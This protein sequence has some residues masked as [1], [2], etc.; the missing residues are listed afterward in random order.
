MTR[1]QVCSKLEDDLAA[2]LD[3]SDGAVKATMEEMVRDSVTLGE[4]Q[5]EKARLELLLKEVGAV[6]FSTLAPTR[7]AFFSK[8]LDQRKAA[9]HTL[10]G[11]ATVKLNSLGAAAPASS[12]VP[13]T[14]TSGTAARPPQVM[15]VTGGTAAGPRD[16][17]TGLAEVA[18]SAAC[19]S[20]TFTRGRRPCTVSTTERRSPFTPLKP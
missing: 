10:V 12:A 16:A 17:T 7:R 4:V 20:A 8:E 13:V 1:K 11:F 18:A 9:L 15:P 6:S 3:R 5:H 2:L 19:E 14:G